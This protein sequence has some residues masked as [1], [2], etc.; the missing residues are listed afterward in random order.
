MRIITKIFRLF[1]L[2][3]AKSG[4]VEVLTYATLAKNSTVLN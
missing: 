1:I 2:S 4:E 3:M